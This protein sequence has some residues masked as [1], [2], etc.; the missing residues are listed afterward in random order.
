MNTLCKFP[1]R[2]PSSFHLIHIFWVDSAIKKNQIVIYTWEV[3][4]ENHFSGDPDFG[5]KTY[6]R[7]ICIKKY[8]EYIIFISCVEL[9]NPECFK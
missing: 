1:A 9:P 3:Y 6:F 4:F 5:F 2:W 7:F 8:R